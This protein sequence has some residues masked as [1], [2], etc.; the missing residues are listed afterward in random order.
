MERKPFHEVILDDMKKESTAL[1]ETIITDDSALRKAGSYF[2]KSILPKGKK[3]EITFELKKMSLKLVGIAPATSLWI[4]DLIR[5][6]EEEMQ[7]T[8]LHP[9]VNAIDLA[10]NYMSN[11]HEEVIKVSLLDQVESL[12]QHLRNLPWVKKVHS[13]CLELEKGNDQTEILRALLEEGKKI[14]PEG[15]LY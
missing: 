3:A 5:N 9:L 13:A 1:L 15:Y 2:F 6:I 8:K 12:P 10:V 14:L 7:Q 11:I 4:D